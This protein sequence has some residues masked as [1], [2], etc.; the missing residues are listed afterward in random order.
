MS[1]PVPR[2]TLH[3]ARIGALRI[4]SVVAV[5]MVVGL[6]GGCARV[7]TSSMSPNDPKYWYTEAPREGPQVR[8]PGN[9]RT[10]RPLGGAV[11]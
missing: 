3:A 5:L 9:E 2:I 6:L 8:S 10:Y 4:H 1:G 11:Y 7:Q